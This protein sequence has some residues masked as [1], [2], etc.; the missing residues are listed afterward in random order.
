MHDLA[1]QLRRQREAPRRNL[2]A[3]HRAEQQGDG[4]GDQAE[5][6]GDAHGRTSSTTKSE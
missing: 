2:H 4:K 6:A 1:L 3:R 5:I